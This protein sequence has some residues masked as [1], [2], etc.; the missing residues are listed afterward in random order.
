MKLLIAFT[1]ASCAS[2]AMVGVL[3]TNGSIL[4]VIV[5]AAASIGFAQMA[6][7]QFDP[8]LA[9]VATAERRG[10]ISGLAVSLG[11]IGTMLGLAVVAGL[12][13]R[14]GDKQHAFIPLAAVY[15][16]CALPALLLVRQQSASEISAGAHRVRT[17]VWRNNLGGVKR[18]LAGRFLYCDALLT[19]SGFLTVFMHRIGGFSETAQSIVLGAAVLAAAVAAFACGRAAERVGAQMAILAALPPAIVA[20]VGAAVFAE[21]WSVWVAAP[22]VGA[23]LGGVWAADRVLMLELAPPAL[24]GELFAYFN[25]ANRVATAFGPLVIWGGTVWLLSEHTAVLSRLDATRVAVALLAATAALG[26]I[27]VKSVHRSA[28]N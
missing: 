16:L 10:R 27:F 21:P 6:I 7:A 15:A 24:R 13:V 19:V 28:G 25:L 1:L 11:F 4:P 17:R 26:W 2:C 22:L 5:T 9:E 12:I 8:L 23:S 18:F 14:G 20:L 3:P